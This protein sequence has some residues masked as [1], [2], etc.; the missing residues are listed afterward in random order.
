MGKLKKLKQFM[1]RSK[2]K[3]PNIYCQKQ[4]QRSCKRNFGVIA[5]FLRH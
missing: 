5:Y 4:K 3:D 1:Q 2:T